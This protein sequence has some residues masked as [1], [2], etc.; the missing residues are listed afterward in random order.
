[1]AKKIAV[2]SVVELL[3]SFKKH[4]RF[5]SDRFL[6]AAMAGDVGI[7]LCGVDGRPTSHGVRK[8]Y[9]CVCFFRDVGG[10]GDDGH[11]SGHAVSP[12]HGQTCWKGDLGVL[13]DPL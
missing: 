11:F 10:W 13:L 4:K 7:V 12:G 5:Y 3:P 9:F 8:I 1:M 6:N 2:G